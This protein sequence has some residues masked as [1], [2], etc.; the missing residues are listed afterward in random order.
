METEAKFRVPGEAAFARLRA[1]TQFGEYERRD[2][3]TKEVH[4]RYL[5][6][7]GLNF[8]NRGLCLRL[9]KG[10]EG[11]LI[12]TIKGL[13]RQDVGDGE[14]AGG[15]A[16]R[17]EYETSVRGLTISRWPES[18]AKQ[19]AK[20]IAGRQ[21][22]HDLVTVDQTRTVS[23]LYD[24]E[25]AVAELS[26]DE[27]KFLGDNTSRQAEPNFEIEAELLPDGTIADVR[28]LSRIFVEEYGLEAQPFSKFEQAIRLSDTGVQES[29]GPD[30]KRVFT[31]KKRPAPMSPG[32]PP[33]PSLESP[34]ASAAPPVTAVKKVK[35]QAKH[36][37]EAPELK[38]APSK[39][40]KRPAIAASASIEAA[41]AVMPTEPPAPEAKPEN[42]AAE[43]APAEKIIARKPKPTLNST[44]S[45]AAAGRKVIRHFYEAMLDNEEGSRLGEDLDSVH[46]MRVATRRMRA[47]MRVFGP[48]LKSKRAG[49]VN[50]GVRDVAQA[51]GEVRDLDVLIENAEQFRTSLPGDQQA[52]LPGMVEE[53]RVKRWKLRKS[54]VKL[55]DSKE[56]SKL[57]RDMERFLDEEVKPPDETEGAQPYQVR[58]FV[59]S[60]VMARYEAVR[61]FEALPGEPT[62]TQIHALRIVGK[63]FRYSLEFFRDVL[64]KDVAAMIRDITKLQDN[65]GELHDADVA[66]LLVL[67]Y[68]AS[69]GYGD[70]DKDGP[71][72]PVGLSAYLDHLQSVMDDKEKDYVGTWAEM[73]SPEWRRKLAMTLVREG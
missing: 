62:I 24:G 66:R 61:A 21:P 68:A 65:L 48:Y 26:L 56:Y 9:R 30:G 33:A 15:I 73:Q 58:H 6:T 23:R 69:R 34:A 44:D 17:E 5:D 64:G 71:A 18:E 10:K 32:S 7:P 57:K 53:W 1:I 55:L 35:K 60:V 31:K 42:P 20:E 54:L 29:E 8:L 28:A 12:I 27:V 13:E 52:G 4:D 51:L 59:G 14:E 22:L 36:I 2:E 3:R 40:R 39:K 11:D 38:A 63:Y 46:D 41:D 25:R 67:D 43:S 47:A 72:L 49:E 50:T 16:A 45:M 70:P 37:T 19:I